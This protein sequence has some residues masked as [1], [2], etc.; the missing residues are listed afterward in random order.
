MLPWAYPFIMGTAILAGFLLSRNQRAALGLSR[1]E[2]LAIALGAF[3]GAM[4]GAKLPFLFADWNGFLTGTAWLTGGKTILGGLV[5]GY[6]GV[7]LAKWSL[8]IKVRT[9]DTFAVAVPVSIAIGRLGCLAAGCCYGTPTDL[10]WGIAFAKTAGDALKRHPTQIYEAMFH[11]TAAGI[12]YV[13][14]RDG[15]CKGQLIRLYIIAYCGYRFLSEF[16]RPE[17]RMWTG[18]TGYQW[19]ALVIAAGFM[20]LVIVSWDDPDNVRVAKQ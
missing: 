16:I 17:A 10:P 18:L 12:L 9:G 8:D 6:L 5:G 13:M 2:R 15:L 7:E 4:V 11:L 1:G 19:A 3:C 20:A 14:K